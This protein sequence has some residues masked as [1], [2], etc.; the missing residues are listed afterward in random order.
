MQ[1]PPLWNK[2]QSLAI[3][4]SLRDSSLFELWYR[5]ITPVLQEHMDY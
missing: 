1:K 2:E 5:I 4:V 3:D